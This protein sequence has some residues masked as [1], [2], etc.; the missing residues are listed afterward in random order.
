MRLPTWC[1]FGAGSHRA[2]D[3]KGRRPGRSHKRTDEAT[4]A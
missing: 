3:V 1:V 4:V 2:S